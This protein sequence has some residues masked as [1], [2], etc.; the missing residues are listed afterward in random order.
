[1][2][3]KT[4]GKII[5]ALRR[6][7]WFYPAGVER[8]KLQK[9]DKALFE[10]E[11]CGKFCYE[12]KSKKTLAE[13]IKKYPNKLVEMDQCQKDHLN[14]FIPIQKGWVWSWD[15]IINNL[16]CGIEGYKILCKTGCHAAKTK[17]EQEQRKELRKLDK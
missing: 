14:P 5:N 9:R 16:F 8:K 4:K 15:D 1:V 6:I 3:A 12:G 17:L 2:D 7:S 10:C 13:Y 11:G